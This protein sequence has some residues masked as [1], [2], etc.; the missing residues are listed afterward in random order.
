YGGVVIGTFSGGVGGTLTVTF[1][2]A[3]TSA[4]IEALIENLTYANVSDAP[5]HDRTLLLNITDADG[6][7]IGP[8]S[9]TAGFTELVGAANPFFGFDYTQPG[10]HPG[11]D[12]APVFVDLDGDGDLDAVVG[13]RFAFP[14]ITLENVGDDADADTLPDFVRLTGTANPLNFN[15]TYRAVPDFVDLDHD[16]DLDLVMGSDEGQIVCYENV[17]DDGDA[18]AFA[19]FVQISAGSPLSDVGVFG[20][21]MPVFLD[22]DGDGDKDAILG[23]SNGTF[24]TY[25]NVGDNGDAGAFD[26]FVELFDTRNPFHG[27]DI[28]HRSAPS[29]ADLDGDGDQDLIVGDNQGIL[30]VFDNVG[31]GGDS[32]AIAEFIELTGSANPLNGVDVGFSAKASFVDLNGDGRLDAV[33][34]EL[35][36]ALNAYLN[37]P[38][39][40]AAIHIGV[41]AVNDAPT[42]AGLASALTVSGDA[43]P[44]VMD[45]SVALVDPDVFF[46]SGT[47]SVSGLLA[48]DLVAIRNEGTGPGQIGVSGADITY[49][50]MLIGTV[51]GGVGGTLTISFN[52]VATAV[53]IDAVIQN[54]TYANASGT[55]TASRTLTLNLA[56]G[57]GASL[58]G[59]GQSIAINVITGAAAVAQ[60]DAVSTDEATPL[61]GSL[62]SNNGSGADSDSDGPSPGVAAVNGSAANVG[63]AI[64]LASGARLTVD[65]DGTFT[66]D[67]T[68]P[69]AVLPAP[70]SGASNTPA[71]DSFT[72]TLAG[73]ATATVTLTITGIDNNDI[74]VGTAGDDT[75]NAGVGNDILA[76]GGGADTLIGGAGDDLYWIDSLDDVVTEYAD[77]GVDEIRTSL[78]YSLAP[79]ANVENLTGTFTGGQALTGNSGDNRITGNAGADTID[80]GAGH[81][82]LWGA[83]GGDTILGGDGNDQMKGE[84][85]SDGMIGGLGNDTIEGGLGNDYLFGD[86]GIDTL[87]GDDDRDWIEGG[88]GVDTLYGGTGDDHLDGGA[89]GDFMYG[90]NGTD[91]LLGG[92]GDDHLDGGQ[93]SDG[94]VG[95]AGA[96]TIIGGSGVD[97]LYGQDG[98]DIITGGDDKDYAEGGAGADTISGGGGDDFI[99]GGADGDTL[100]GDDNVDTL[101]GEDG[102]DNL[103]GG[104]GND[105]LV[106]G[107]GA[108]TLTGGAGADFFAF[109]AALGA[110][111]IDTILD[112][113]APNDTILLDD[114]V[115]VGLTPGPLGTAGFRSGAAAMDADDRIIY[116]SATGALFYDSDGNGAGA[117]VQFASLQTGLVLTANDFSV[118]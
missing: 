51:S 2:A 82:I 33:V 114:A 100:M 79:F 54:I 60:N 95:G 80:G 49:G 5:T 97:W 86:D 30:R 23:F 66:Y 63:V 98:D 64:L 69:F 32:G 50:S 3:A 1:N 39:R 27:V 88:A 8:S 109:T 75:L 113:S 84:V 46:G 43:T 116:N 36:S 7:D 48:E 31:D 104:A 34:G 15:G 105:G 24:R 22:L 93:A 90:E 11:V 101:L 45:G 85:G 42:L 62:F 47:L 110:A 40:G 115:F 12:L 81:D 111:N 102:D 9:T 28:G 71:T 59:G 52:D 72:Y 37:V 16:G 19:S 13:S 20:G 89:D 53:A 26:N 83:D 10:G 65:V 21:S 58:T 87:K 17:G 103:Q 68:A 78:A 14:L 38:G 41:A 76:G 56:D 99:L 55:P 112:Y 73:G 91:T 118:I 96:D 117:A 70:G 74:L 61:T 6:A 106:G 57:A 107:A 44:R 35:E 29:A 77:E 94:L 67:P 18:D 25:E 4:A 92:D 108:D